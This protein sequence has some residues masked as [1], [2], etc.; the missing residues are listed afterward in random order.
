MIF[1][2][3]WKQLSKYAKEQGVSII[4]DIPIYVAMDSADTWANPELFQLDAQ[5]RP[6]AVA[7]CPP[8]AFTADGQLWGNPLYRWDVMA[9]DGYQ[10]WLDRI[11]A[12]LEL[13]DAVRIDHFRGFESYYAIPYGEVT[14]RNGKW[15]KGPG[16]GLIA[17]IKQSF[18]NVQIIA[19]DLG[20][21]TQEVKELLSYS[22][23]PGMKIIQFAFDSREKVTIF[24]LSIQETVWFIQERMTMRQH[25]DG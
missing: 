17:A 15:V 6:T 7:G 13:F 11:R 24:L 16:K 23:F 8:D 9:R 4:G 5:C 25:L 21:L 2:E 10:W 3:Q 18:P 1:F 20:F 19:E 12:S 14:A 22:G